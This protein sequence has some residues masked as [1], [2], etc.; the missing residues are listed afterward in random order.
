MFVS[1]SIQSITFGRH[2]QLNFLT[3]RLVD[4]T[5]W[6]NE[7]G[8]VSLYCTNNFW[9]PSCGESFNLHS[10]LVL[11]PW[12]SSSITHRNTQF[13][14]Y[15]LSLHIIDF[16]SFALPSPFLFKLNLVIRSFVRTQ[17][18]INPSIIYFFF[19]APLQLEINPPKYIPFFMN[20]HKE[21]RKDGTIL[22][23]T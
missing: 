15:W 1:K 17:C 6:F 21:G 10:K 4:N 12:L 8:W 9:F 7:L 3:D 11:L 16:S 22:L 13:I 5:K 18:Q 2:H 20:F 23:Y 19:P 14:Y